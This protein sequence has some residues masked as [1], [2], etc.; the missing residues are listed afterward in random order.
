M[1]EIIQIIS[2]FSNIFENIKS[3][4][5]FSNTLEIFTLSKTR[6]NVR[7]INGS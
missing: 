4:Y 6:F 7:Q 2:Y 5:I 1:F 3:F